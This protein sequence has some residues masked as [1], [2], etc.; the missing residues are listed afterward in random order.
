MRGKSATLLMGWVILSLL[1]STA[2]AGCG[3]EEKAAEVEETVA[4]PV[5]TEVK[6]EARVVNR[7]GVVLPADAAPIEE[8]VMRYA[9]TEVTWLTWDASVYDENVGDLFAWA[10][11][12]V[13]PTNSTSRSPTPA[14]AG[15][16]RPTA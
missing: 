14:K 16:P 5:A 1:A 2:L 6:E 7:A 15:R 11:S 8:Q 3:G 12:C 9:E 4:E 13:R 10:D